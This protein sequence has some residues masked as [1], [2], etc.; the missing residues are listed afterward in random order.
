MRPS[1][2]ALPPADGYDL[3]AKACQKQL[4]L[5]FPGAQPMDLIDAWGWTFRE[6][7]FATNGTATRSLLLP[8]LVGGFT[9]LVNSEHEPTPAYRDWLLWHEIAHSFYF[10]DGVPAA[11]RTP[12]LREEETFCNVF[13]DIALGLTAHSRNVT[14]AA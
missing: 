9:V 8:K 2:L 13:A 3:L 4:A 5:E 7:R 12:Y 10:T 11:R 1:L 14:S 6:R